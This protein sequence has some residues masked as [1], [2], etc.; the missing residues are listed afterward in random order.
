VAIGT[1]LVLAGLL[2]GAAVYRLSVRPDQPSEAASR[3]GG[4]LPADY[5]TDNSPE[6]RAFRATCSQCHVL[7]SPLAYDKAGWRAVHTRMAAQM[8][9][10]GLAIPDSQIELAIRYVI[11]HGQGAGRPAAT[12]PP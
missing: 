8:A 11:A 3:P 10:R 9:A 12:G 6:A 7:P 5:R 1:F 4:Y 2:V